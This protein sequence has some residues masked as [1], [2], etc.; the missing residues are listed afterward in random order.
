[1]KACK[2]LFLFVLILALGACGIKPKELSP[3]DAKS[4]NPSVFP[5]QYPNPDL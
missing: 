1:M 3:P 4:D 5:Q 2:P